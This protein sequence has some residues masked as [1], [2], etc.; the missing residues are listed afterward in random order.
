MV[1]IDLVRRRYH[2]R[3][4]LHDY[5]VSLSSSSSSLGTPFS[6]V[7][8]VVASDEEEVYYPTKMINL[9]LLLY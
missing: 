8:V 2:P 1:M 7:A 9:D 6:V 4:H 3:H 5:C